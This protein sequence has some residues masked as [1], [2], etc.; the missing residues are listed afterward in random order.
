MAIIFVEAGA[1]NF[2]NREL[3]VVNIENQKAEEE[4]VSFSKLKIKA[5][6]AINKPL[7]NTGC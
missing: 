1:S 5:E 2:E 4:A 7:P 3:E 6:A